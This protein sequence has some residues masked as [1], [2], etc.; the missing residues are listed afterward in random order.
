MILIVHPTISSE[1]IEQLKIC[2]PDADYSMTNPISN[3]ADNIS[4][5][6]N[7][8][9][10]VIKD[11]SEQKIEKPNLLINGD[12]GSKLSAQKSGSNLSRKD[13]EKGNDAKSATN[14]TIIRHKLDF[15]MFSLTG[16]L[17]FSVLQKVFSFPLQS[18]MRKDSTTDS[19]VCGTKEGVTPRETGDIK[20]I[21]PEELFKTYSIDH[22]KTNGCVLYNL[23]VE[24]PRFHIPYKKQNPFNNKKHGKCVSN[25]TEINL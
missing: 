12:V 6:K 7:D 22:I 5:D 15:V 19:T 21:T 23:I 14:M 11:I 16:P 4:S 17:S 25:S 2:F 8:V 18:K 3:E 13:C 20:T 10:S 9:N 24:D 1:L